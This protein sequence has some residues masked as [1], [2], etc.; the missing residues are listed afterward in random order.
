VGVREFDTPG[1]KAPSSCAAEERP[2]A[3]A[4]GYL[5]AKAETSG[6]LEAKAK[7]SG[8]LE[9][10]AEA[11]ASGYLEAG[12]WTGP[13]DKVALFQLGSVSIGPRL[14]R[15]RLALMAAMM[16]SSVMDPGRRRWTGA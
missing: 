8:Y 16:S 7:A 2:E 15:R 12:G 10:R 1:A 9:A 14:Q 6:Y 4:S 13:V 11:E 3:E 5:E